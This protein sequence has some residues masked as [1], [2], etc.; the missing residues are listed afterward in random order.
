MEWYN[1]ML[2]LW[3]GCLKIKKTTNLIYKNQC[4][5]VCS[6]FMNRF[7]GVKGVKADWRQRV[8]RVGGV[9]SD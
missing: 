5:Y 4:V 8:Q 6:S 2:N 9:E 1:L 3:K 7:G